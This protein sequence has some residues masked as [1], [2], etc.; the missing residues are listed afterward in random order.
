MR[1]LALAA[2]AVASNAA[3]HKN[4]AP[5]GHEEGQ[6]YAPNCTIPNRLPD[7][8]VAPGS[9][10]FIWASGLSRPRGLQKAANNDVLVIERGR[11]ISIL[12]DDNGN[13]VSDPTERALLVGLTSLNHG[14]V[15]D[16]VNEYLYASSNTDVFRWKWRSGQ[17]TPLG[18][19]EHVVSQVPGNGHTTRTIVFEPNNYDILYLQVGSVGNVD[20]TP[21]QTSIRRYDVNRGSLPIVWSAGEMIADGLRNEVALRF[22]NKERLW[23]IENGVDNL[24]RADLGGSIVRDNPAEEMNIIDHKN[25]GKFYGYPYC[26]SEFHIPNFGHFPGEQWVQPDFQSTHTDEWCRDTRNV[27]RPVFNFGA[28]IAPLDVIFDPELPPAD[29]RVEQYGWASFHGSWNRD[30]AQGYELRNIRLIKRADNGTDSLE[31]L[32]VHLDVDVESDPVMKYRG[33]GETGPGWI[34]PVA[35]IIVPCGTYSTDPNHLCPLVS[36]DTTGHLVGL[37]FDSRT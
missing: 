27:V 14:I 8:I 32:G 37:A 15:I 17:R 24:A 16:P 25:P 34:R 4:W 29:S 10:P 30:P 33:P 22:D 3:E 28:H 1:A 13:G 7:S 18:A 35:V 26:F 36:S 9:C 12:W 6:L 21:F 20:R 11:G 31:R 2:L 19:S 23:G 5:H